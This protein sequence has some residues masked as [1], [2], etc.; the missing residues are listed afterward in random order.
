MKKL[1]LSIGILCCLLLAACSK[2][3]PAQPNVYTL[4]LTEPSPSIA[5]PT[6]SA[7]PTVARSTP[8][9]EPSRI[10]P[11]TLTAE[12]P[13]LPTEPPTSPTE[14]PTQPTTYT[15]IS[16]SSAIP[17]SQYPACPLRDNVAWQTWRKV[18]EPA[19]V[20]ALA[21]D[22]QQVWFS[23]S[24][25]TYHL[26]TQTGAY[27]RYRRYPSVFLF[28][29]LEEGQVWATD[30]QGLLYYDG[31]MWLRP[32]LSP[33]VAYGGAN[34]LGVDRNGDLWLLSSFGRGVF[35]IMQ[36]P[37]HVPPKDEVWEPLLDESIYEWNPYNCDWW[38]AYADNRITYHTTEECQQLHET[39]NQVLGTEIWGVYATNGRDMW[40]IETGGLL[41]HSADGITQSV[42]ISVGNVYILAADSNR[43]VWAGTSQG[44]FHIDE[45]GAQRLDQTMGI[46]FCALPASALDITVDTCGTAWLATN[47][48]LHKLSRSSARWEPVSDTMLDEAD[49]QRTVMGIGAAP[50]GGVWATHGWDLWKINE[51]APVQLLPDLNL[52][53]LPN[54]LV[55]DTHN[56][57]W[58]AASVCG[59][60]QYLPT[61]ETWIKR[62]PGNLRQG[63][64]AGADGAVYSIGEKRL[65][66]YTGTTQSMIVSRVDIAVT[67]HLQAIAGDSHGG[68]WIN[69]YNT[70][71]VWYMRDGHQTQ[72][73]GAPEDVIGV[74]VDAQDRLWMYTQNSLVVYDGNKVT[75]IGAPL[76]GIFKISLGPDGRVWVISESGVAVYNPN[77]AGR[78]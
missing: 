63:L 75:K 72:L 3:P 66:V 51:I 59:V 46:D 26:D 11:S 54:S 77:A 13:M 14:F 45:T 60:W 52:S 53:C 47:R 70:S 27:T 68:V 73:E 33:G 50:A 17:A 41:F 76:R 19:A 38:Q 56:T 71:H 9:T 22:G 35:N 43:G 67:P 39:I 12:C 37:G 18:P 25:G 69:E 4:S 8:L 5:P 15:L 30:N 78:P 34:V 10:A 58:V 6:P 64:S 48:G 2:T 21:V 31:Q 61:T 62:N 32:K 28:L 49:R 24:F 23:D 1:L 44:L 7:Q 42:S 55:V 74:I 16:P 57:V 40:R 29:P 20:R 36:Y 65:N